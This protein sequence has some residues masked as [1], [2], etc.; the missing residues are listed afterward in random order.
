MMIIETRF[1]E[2]DVRRNKNLTSGRMKTPISF[3]VRVVA[4]KNAGKCPWA[5]LGFNALSDSDIHY[6][7]NN[8]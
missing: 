8:M 4:Y 1:I 7:A 5:K 3:G 2:L 6:V